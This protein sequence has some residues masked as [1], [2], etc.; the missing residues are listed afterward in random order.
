ME[1]RTR[2]AVRNGIDIDGV[3]NR[4][5]AAAGFCSGRTSDYSIA[6]YQSGMNA[7]GNQQRMMYHP[8]NGTTRS[9]QHIR[10]YSTPSLRRSDLNDA[11]QM[12]TNV[13]LCKD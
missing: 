3:Q 1:C 8:F 4:W 2:S 9:V 11:Q 6:R 13:L 12:R 5:H 7:N 10:F